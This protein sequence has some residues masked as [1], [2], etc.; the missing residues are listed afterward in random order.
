MFNEILWALR[1]D[2]WSWE[3]WLYATFFIL[4][5]WLMARGRSAYV[6][7]ALAALFL[8]LESTYISSALS[9]YGFQQARKQ[10]ESQEVCADIQEQADTLDLKYQ[11]CIDSW[12]NLHDPKIK[13]I[14]IAE[15]IFRALCELLRAAAFLCVFA[16]L[17]NNELRRVGE[18]INWY[19]ARAHHD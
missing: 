10:A 1:P 4:S 18:V 14:Y 19:R 11:E 5:L 8:L 12:V 15:F 2:N 3:S 6:A 7:I 13:L 16:M 17:K 9:G